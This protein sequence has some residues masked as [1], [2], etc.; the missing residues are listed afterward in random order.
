VRSESK[1]HDVMNQAKC[2]G[3]T[4]AKLDQK[5]F[6]GGYAGYFDPDWHLQ[7]RL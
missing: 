5:T 1:F 4:I 6:W 2:T 7:E 3:A